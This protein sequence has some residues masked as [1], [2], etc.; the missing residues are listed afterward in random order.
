MDWFDQ[1]FSVCS[2]TNSHEI[3]TVIHIVHPRWCKQWSVLFIMSCAGFTLPVSS[4]K[5]SVCY[6][7]DTNFCQLK[8]VGD[9]T[10]GLT[11]CRELDLFHHGK[12]V[13][14][15]A[16][17]RPLGGASMTSF[18]Y[19]LGELSDWM[20]V[21]WGGFSLQAVVLISLLSTLPIAYLTTAA[22][23]EMIPRPAQPVNK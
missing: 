10:D 2:D 11:W 13:T 18:W 23:W 20:A 1:L 5:L 17:A 12:Q 21:P 9:E 7:I 22:W 3:L 6:C 19:L 15:L 4:S 8:V 14:Y 16:M